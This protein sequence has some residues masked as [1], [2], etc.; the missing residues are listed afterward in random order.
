MSADSW[1]RCPKCDAFNEDEDEDS[2]YY[3]TVRVDHWFSSCEF[4]FEVQFAC[5]ECRWS[6]KLT[7]KDVK[8]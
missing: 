5:R 4:A 6:Y 3:G 7:D 1:M 2:E 8:V